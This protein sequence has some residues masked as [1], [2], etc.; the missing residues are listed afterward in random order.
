VLR[1]ETT[2]TIA[3]ERYRRRRSWIFIIGTN[4]L[5]FIFL[6]L[7]LR[8]VDLVGT[9]NEATHMDWRWLT[10]GAVFNV[11]VFLLQACRWWYLLLP[12]E[13][14]HYGHFVRATYV[15]LYA[16]ELLPLRAGELIRCFLLARSSRIP[17]SVSFASAL[18]ERLFDGVWLMG[19]FFIALKI[20]RLPRAMVRGGDVLLVIIVVLALI[21]AYGMYGRKQTMNLLFFDVNL[22]SWFNTLIE[23]LHLIGHSRFL[24]YSFF[25]S[26]VS[27]ILQM[28]PIFAIVRAYHLSLPWQASFTAMVLLRIST[29]LPQ[30]P[31][32]IGLFNWVTARTLAL[33]GLVL[34]Q[35]K[36]FSIVLWTAVT[37]PLIA[38][39]FVI[40]LLA[41]IDMAHLHRQATHAAANRRDPKGA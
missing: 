2:T 34:S 32:N 8:G 36:G 1:D 18:I 13:R 20:G 5:S 26:G 10:F 38:V 21:L 22:P 7:T 27:M 41:G 35:A 23:D 15:G 37:L 28:V 4:L 30:A 24:Y 16:N 12:V 40:L 14:A 19:C 29:A 11:L 3:A 25:V 31:G 9:W 33:Y 39:G 6:W 17:L